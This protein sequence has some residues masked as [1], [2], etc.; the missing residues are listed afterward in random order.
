METQHQAI[1]KGVNTARNHTSQINYLEFRYRM[2]NFREELIARIGLQLFGLEGK[3]FAEAF[4][5]F[6]EKNVQ[7]GQSAEVVTGEFM[8]ELKFRALPVQA[9]DDHLPTTLKGPNYEFGFGGSVYKAI[10]KCPAFSNSPL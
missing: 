2:R 1:V 8:T 7:V 10:G 5:L 4:S 3:D 6:L 9:H